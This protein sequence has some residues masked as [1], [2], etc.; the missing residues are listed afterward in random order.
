VVVVIDAHD[1]ERDS[2]EDLISIRAFKPNLSAT[3]K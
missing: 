1:V 2:P 3:R